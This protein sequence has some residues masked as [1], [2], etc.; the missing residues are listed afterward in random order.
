M[1][2]EQEKALSEH[3]GAIAKILYSDTSPSE[4]TTL[5]QI[6]TTVR[7]KVLNY[8]SPELG[9]FDQRSHKN[10]IRKSPN[11]EKLSRKFAHDTLPN[12]SVTS[13]LT[14]DLLLFTLAI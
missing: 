12:N 5:E 6:E 14:S 10:S 1:T 7:D 13:L 4:L 3:I 9:F 8:V 2:P 11:L